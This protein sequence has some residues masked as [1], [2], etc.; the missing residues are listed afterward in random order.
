MLMTTPNCVSR[1]IFIDDDAFHAASVNNVANVKCGR[2]SSPVLL[3][4][5]VMESI[6]D[7]EVIGLFFL[8]LREKRVDR[9]P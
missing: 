5:H 1:S 7:I 2:P 8:F 6:G 3:H 4:V 9:M